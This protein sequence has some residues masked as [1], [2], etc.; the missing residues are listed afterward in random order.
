MLVALKRLA[1]AEFAERDHIKFE[2][3]ISYS[4]VHDS[5]ANVIIGTESRGDTDSLELAKGNTTANDQFFRRV[6]VTIQFSVRKIVD[7]GRS[8]TNVVQPSTRN[9]EVAVTG[10]AGGGVAI[11]ATMVE[12]LLK[13]RKTQQ[14]VKCT[15]NLF[16]ASTP[17]V[18]GGGAQR[19]KEKWVF[20]KTDEPAGWDD[21][22]D[23]SVIMTHRGAS[24]FGVGWEK[25]TLGFPTL[26]EDGINVSDWAT[27]GSTPSVGAWIMSG[28]LTLEK[29]K[30]KVVPKVEH[31]LQPTV[32]T[33]EVFIPI[34]FDTKKSQV[35][36]NALSALAD[37]VK[38][39]T[40][41][42]KQRR[43]L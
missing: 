20:F 29:P 15:A 9:W 2:H 32:E 24:Y 37:L 10:M 26:V 30:D 41:Q 43:G 16:G 17:A 22:K 39:A 40:A 23:T 21:F 5:T 1:R 11:G 31:D 42:F 13:N 38:Q 34:Y 35:D 28:S 8:T 12:L 7:A 33:D 18:G 14:V 19:G 3:D 27:G 4:N 36:E 25:T 6:D